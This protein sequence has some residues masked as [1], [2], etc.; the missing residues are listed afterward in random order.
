M[1]KTILVTGASSFIG[2]WIVKYLLEKGYHVR[3]T[4]RSQAKEAQVLDGISNEHRSQISFVYIADI[5]TDSFDEAVQGIDGII[6]VASPFHFKVNDPEK[7]MILPA[8][9]G[10]VRILQAAHEYNQKNQNQIKRIVITSSFAS[11]FDPSQGFRP[12]YSYTEKDWCPLTYEQG[13]AAKNDPL[14]VYRVS[15]VC[16]ERA[17]WDF[18]EKEKPAFTIATICEPMVFGPSVNGFKSSDDI[19]TSNGMIWSVVTSGKDAK[20]PE[21]RTPWQVD[22][23]DVARTHIAALEQM[24]ETNE[25]YLIAAETW[26]H[27]RAI[28]IIHESTTIPTSIKDT[29]PT[30]TKGQRLSDHFDIDSSKAQKELG[31]TFIPFEKTVED[32]AL[33]FAQ[34]QEKLQHH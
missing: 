18:V 5:T 33:Q 28:D 12:G 7:D 10:T 2:G 14:T 17:A 34:L 19:H 1:P 29:T 3:G 9:H 4:V 24:T 32:L 27:Q 20:V 13:A 6:H 26:S 22:V 8:I 15:K 31:I 30:G 11:I 25:R 21:I 23:R 16:A